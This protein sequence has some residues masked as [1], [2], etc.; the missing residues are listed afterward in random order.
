[1]PLPYELDSKNFLLIHIKDIL[2]S[3]YSKHEFMLYLINQPELLIFAEA[4]KHFKC[5][6]IP[7]VGY[8]VNDAQ[9][10]NEILKHPNFTSGGRGGMGSLITPFTGEYGLFN[11]DGAAHVTFKR[12]LMKVFNREY[13]NRCIEVAGMCLVRQLEAKLQAGQAVD[14]VDFTR[15]FTTRIM[16]YMFGVDVDRIDLDVVEPQITD[17][18]MHYMSKLH[19]RK[20]ELTDDESHSVFTKIH[21][22]DKLIAECQRSDQSDSLLSALYEMGLSKEEARGLMYSFLVAGTETT[23]ITIP[24]VLALL[25]DSGQFELLKADLSLMGNTL[26]EGI[27]MTTASPMIPRA[28]EQDTTIGKHHF[29]AGSRALMIVYNILKQ[30]YDLDNAR[31]FDITRSIPQRIKHLNFGHGAHFCIG[32]PLAHRELEVVLNSILNLEKTPTIQAR[33][34]S[35]GQTFPAYT[36]LVVAS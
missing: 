34:Y 19:L 24:R 9:L 10:A 22:V 26:E 23:N 20:I 5:L 29:K 1:M 33:S 21:K 17:A 7:K 18:V 4:I 11:M 2:V 32:F 13:V 31:Y 12:Q 27:R 16:L 8:L 15:K 36:K 6:Y 30:G 3:F 35:R 14:I 28:I 25:L